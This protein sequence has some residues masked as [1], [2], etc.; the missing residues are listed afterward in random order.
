MSQASDVNYNS[1]SLTDKYHHYDRQGYSDVVDQYDL[2]YGAVGSTATVS[3][4]ST[5][6]LV[7]GVPST[8]SII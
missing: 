2:K 5:P 6:P 4:L 3:A 8:G 1:R 7:G